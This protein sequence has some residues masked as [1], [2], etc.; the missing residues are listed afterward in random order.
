MDETTHKTWW[1]LHLRLARN[2]TLNAEEQ[3]TYEAGLQRLDQEE[4]LN[5]D[6]STLR[7][8]RSKMEALEAENA[9]LQARRKK[10]EK[11]IVFLEAGLSDRKRNLL[12][13]EAD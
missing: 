3:A 9:Q 11:E 1:A 10:L 6:V 7:Q 4:I 5:G 13:A 8:A 12:D 2:E